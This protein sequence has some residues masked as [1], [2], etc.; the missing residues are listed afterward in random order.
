MNTDAQKNKKGPPEQPGGK[1]T[2]SSGQ[3]LRSSR[4]GE[5]IFHPKTAEETYRGILGGTQSPE[6]SLACGALVSKKNIEP[7]Q[8]QY[9]LV[10][11]KQRNGIK[12]TARTRMK[13][14]EGKPAQ[15]KLGANSDRS[16]NQKGSMPATK[17]RGR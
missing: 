7:Y 5:T 11:G 10:T 3:K 2:N 1:V 15:D 16:K 4:A 13:E 8:S 6:G 14:G 12:K 17:I 9:R